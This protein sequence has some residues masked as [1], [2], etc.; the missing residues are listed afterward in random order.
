L[1]PRNSRGALSGTTTRA[2]A[3]AAVNAAQR[4][5]LPPPTTA[6]SKTRPSSAWLAGG[7]AGRA[8]N[9]SAAEGVREASKSPDGRCGMAR[10][11]RDYE[12]TRIL[13]YTTIHVNELAE[14]PAGRP[15]RHGAEA[16]GARVARRTVANFRAETG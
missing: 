4:P 6:T 1:P 13:L 14:A 11:C 3:C 5:A 12:F 8:L 15:S 10:V 9:G 7:C 2:P 16:A